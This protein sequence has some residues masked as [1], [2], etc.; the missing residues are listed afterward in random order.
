MSIPREIID[1]IRN[2]TSIAEVI[3]KYVQLTRSGTSLK[4][5]CPFHGEKS[6]S[7]NVN[8][9]RNIFHCFGCQEGGDVFK[10]V[11]KMEN[12]SFAEV[13]EDLGTRV[14]VEIPKRPL[15]PQEQCA[16]SENEEMLEANE[17]AKGFFRNQLAATAGKETREYFKKRGLSQEII[18]EF[19]LG[20]CGPGWDALAKWWQ[21]KKLDPRVGERAGLLIRKS[22]WYDR[23]HDRCVFPVTN[24]RGRVIGFG[25]RKMNAP[26]LSGDAPKYLNSSES[27][28]YKKG[29]AL[30]GLDTARAAIG[31]SDRV[32]VV[33]GYFD[34][35]GLAQAGIKDAIAT[36]GTA[37]TPQHLQILR[38]YAKKIVF[39]YDGDE[40]GQ[41][42]AVRALPL[43]LEAGVAGLYCAVPMGDDPDTWVQK[44]GRDHV[45]SQLDKA[46]PIVD[47]WLA[48]QQEK[49]AKMTNA[50]RRDLLKQL[51][52]VF[53]KVSDPVMQDHYA[54]KLSQALEVNQELVINAIA[55]KDATIAA[56]KPEEKP[57]SDNG[58]QPSRPPW[59]GGK[60][61]R[62]KEE[63]KGP[64]SADLPLRTKL[65]VSSRDDRNLEESLL[66]LLLGSRRVSDTVR[67]QQI[68]RFI[69]DRTLRSLGEKLAE[70][71]VCVT[72]RDDAADQPDVAAVLDGLDLPD[73]ERSVITR[74][75]VAPLQSDAETTWREFQDLVAALEKRELHEQKKKLK[76]EIAAAERSKDSARLLVLLGE[77]RELDRRLPQETTRKREAGD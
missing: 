36:C 59:Q 10:F 39:L 35:L 51:A 3:G 18:D 7:F 60:G 56:G 13:V 42:A 50:E 45:L 47:F 41:K 8:E 49:A 63:P 29:E 65:E 6:P 71:V 17:Q 32:I 69:K 77:M 53:F 38:R 14:G 24:Y 22:N 57:K 55:R 33:E 48:R 11:M 67:A 73:M 37:L 44:A 74:A 9:Q 76:T 15:T 25:G 19:G 4:G 54:S 16:K 52:P 62:W 58:F 64:P 2:R 21:Q 23:F 5:L 66:R 46:P 27:P 28:V 30:Y 26:T 61:R 68:T 12:R 34:V 20:H 31:K 70:A 72:H 75:A 43:L 40:A 1:E